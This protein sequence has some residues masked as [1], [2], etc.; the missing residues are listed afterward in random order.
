MDGIFGAPFISA[1]LPHAEN[2]ELAM[3]HWR[4]YVHVLVHLSG[5][6]EWHMWSA[7]PLCLHYMHTTTARGPGFFAQAPV[8]FARTIVAACAYAVLKER[9]RKKERRKRDKEKER[10]PSK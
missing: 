3:H 10:P 7:S 5:R 9:K 1:F 6:I 2:Y 8:S 4:T